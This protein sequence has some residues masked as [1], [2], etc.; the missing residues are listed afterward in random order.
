MSRVATRVS[1]PLFIGRQAE[2]ESLTGAIARADAGD[3]AVVLVGGEA[4]I[5][6]TRLIDE[7]GTRADADGA[8]ILEGGCVSLGDGGGLPFAPFVEA[9]RRLPAALAGGRFGDI[10]IETLRT[11]A[12]VELGRLMP[13]WGTPAAADA[14]GSGRPEW[15]QARIFEGVLALLRDLGERAPV[16]CILEDLHWADGSTRDLVAFLAR[17]VR[18]ER[19]VVVGTYRTDELH[20]RHPLRPWLSEMDRLPRV[21]R[22]ELSRFGRAELGA[23]VEAI[24][25]RP[26]ESDL[27]EAIERRAEGNPFFIEE[28]LA[29]RA[30]GGEAAAG[31]PD[32][33]REVLLSRVSALSEEAQRVLGMAAVDGRSV[34]PGLLAE[35]A[36]RPEPDLEGPLREALAAQL[37]VSDPDDDGRYRFRHALLA[38]AVYDDLLPSERRRL[39]AGY[40]AALDARPVPDGA[41]GASLLAALAHHATAAHEPVRALRA[42]IAAARAAADSFAFA[43]S[44][45]A[46]EQAIG[47]WD[48]VP[49]DDRPDGVDAA[50]L[51]HEASL[52]AMIGGRLDRA[53]ELARVAVG[54]VDP[55]REPERWA[56]AN[57]R[58]AR[59][60]WV[61]GATQEGTD[62]LE[63]TAAAMKD[64]R[65]SPERARVLASLASAYMLRGGHARAIPAAEA[66]IDLA[67]ATEAALAEA[68]AMST[69]GT[70]LA[71][72]GRCT[73][74]VAI[75]REALARNLADGDVDAI[76]RAYANFSSVLLIC[77]SLEESLEVAGAGTGWARS[78]G[79]SAQYGRFLAG[80]A[81]D[82]AIDLGRWDVAER[83]ID[84]LLASEVFGVTRM[85]ILAVAGTFLVRRGRRA[86]A[87]PLLE[88]G[89][90]LV[91]SMRDAQFTAP[92]HLGLVELALSDGDAVAAAATATDG[93]DRLARTGD[94]YYA[95]D[96]AAMAA[97]AQADVAG[98][99]RARRDDATALDAAA[100]A[101]TATALI[102]RMRDELPEADAF[103]GRLD[104]MTALAQAESHRAAGTASPDAWGAAVA[105]ADRA[106]VAWPIAY[107]R[108]R[109]VETMLEA[110]APR[111]ETEIALADAHA[112]AA[113]LGAAPLREWVE[114]LARRS[115]LPL[116]ERR[117][118]VPDEVP[119]EA[120]PAVAP[121]S[122]RTATTDAA[123][124][125]LGLTRREREVL[126]LVA[127]GHTNK[128]IAELLFI[129]ENTA[130]V[131]VSNI[132]G[133]LGVATRTEA[134]AIAARLGL[135]RVEV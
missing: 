132:L 15:V 72:T 30:G 24:L 69:L 56:A 112:A 58:L 98:L 110:R 39:H 73:E 37:L 85:G 119:G 117:A 25:G 127:A 66:A 43:E 54:L 4:G 123:L 133:K 125:E 1:S 5:G 41:E 87:R 49:A 74:G 46:F 45:R 29:A 96:L 83:T 22:I 107:T 99:A 10:D 113:R 103:G 88:E 102:E 130:G 71:L 129:S 42:W 36:G 101:R 120:L 91:E 105:A 3:P 7:I 82:A 44:V 76:G 78:A 108:F 92:V 63:A 57:E 19:L 114:G 70:S 65:P 28:L 31:L 11:P 89:R 16:V 17:N 61:A 35:V 47:L 60:S 79:A 118:S 116:P 27:L 135:D 104:S 81:A 100:R 126:P 80:N 121:R 95:I 84:E 34:E 50:A 20:R 26:A 33:L 14:A 21:R 48:A 90:A 93:L 62:I 106:R 53:V 55:A 51:H 18:A 122:G 134:A 128:R 111:P 52:G 23:Q 6:K 115:R 9:L 40:A 2:L 97:R 12:T 32:T 75:S 94:H 13:G 109:L 68:H 64:A 86:D 59:A 67:R 124:D 131:H 8:L 38:E 77:G